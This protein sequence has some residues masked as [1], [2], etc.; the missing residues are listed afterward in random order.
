[1]KRLMTLFLLLIFCASASGAEISVQFGNTFGM[2][3]TIP[4]N[5]DFYVKILTENNDG[6]TRETISLPLT[7]YGTGDIDQV[8]HIDV[9][10]YGSTQSIELLYGFEPGGY[11]D[12]VEMAEFSWDGTLPDGICYKASANPG[13]GWPASEYWYHHMSFHLRISAPEYATGQ[14]CVDSTGFGGSYDWLFEEPSPS[15]GGPYCLPA[16]YVI[17]HPPYFMNAPSELH[18]IYSIPFYYDFESGQEWPGWPPYRAKYII[19]YG[20]GTIDSAKGL[21][22]YDPD[23]SEAGDTLNL[24]LTIENQWCGW[25]DW[26]DVDLIVES[27][28]GDAN[29]DVTV[30]MLDILYLIAFLYKGGPEP[31]YFYHADVDGSG[32]INMLDVLALMGYLYKGV[33]ETHC[34]NIRDDFVMRNGAW[35]KYERYDS[36]TSQCDTV[37]VA[38]TGRSSLRYTFYDHTEDESIYIAR[39]SVIT[40]GRSPH[41]MYIFPLSLGNSWVNNS[42]PDPTTDTVVEYRSYVSRVGHIE[43][44]Y[45]IER[46]WIFEDEGLGQTT[47]W[48]APGIGMIY[49][50][51]REY[52]TLGAPLTHETWDLIE[53][54]VP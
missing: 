39:D 40:D 26:A 46:S 10:G 1:M 21:Y 43:D 28:C 15:F 22:T 50:E 17:C 30:N 12:D 41:K 16:A 34:R 6:F 29:G 2:P 47:E 42:A 35:W 8:I 23:I 33:S 32:G 51:F 49:L 53:Y 36:L 52:G 45:R 9:D 4:I 37:Q 38:V 44:A 31:L 54:S 7:F 18:T 20:P 24:V 19:V 48:Y 27:A 5:L 25:E 3:D 11:W 14:F 13:N